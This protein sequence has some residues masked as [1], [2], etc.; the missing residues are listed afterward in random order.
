MLKLFTVI[1]SI[2]FQNGDHN[3][4]LEN[5]L[6]QKLDQYS[7]FEFSITSLPKGLSK[8]DD[9]KLEIINDG[10]FRLSGSYAF[11]PVKLK[12]DKNASA[13]FVTVKLE[14]YDNVLVA[15]R[16]IAKGEMLSNSDFVIEE[17]C[18]TGLRTNVFT[19]VELLGE[20]R[21]RTKISSGLILEDYMLEK[22]PLINTGDFINALFINGSVTISF[23]VTAR[24]QGGKGEI[25]RVS[26]DSKR[27][28]KA[29]VIDSKNVKII[30]Q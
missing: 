11:V 27:I 5:Y 28:F 14:L 24:T 26:D 10:N 22:A 1:L 16:E 9:T 30:G 7:R 23:G 3:N 19:D 12:Y 8:F 17:K 29:E 13:S 20:Y 6:S 15:N 4:S 18:V 25:I 21:S 2:L